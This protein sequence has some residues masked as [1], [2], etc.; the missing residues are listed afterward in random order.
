[1]KKL[2]ILFLT[3]SLKALAFHH[4][5]IVIAT[6]NNEASC[7]RNLISA[8]NQDYPHFRV[9]CINDA[10]TDSTRERI[11]K[12]VAEHEKGHLVH[13]INNETRQRALANYT[14]AIRNHTE[15]HEIIAIL[16]GDDALSHRQV[17]QTLEEYYSDPDVWLTYGQFRFMSTGQQGWCCPMPNSVINAHAFRRWPHGPSHLRTFY[18]WLFKRIALSDLMLNGVFFEMT[19]DLAM[20][21]P[22][23]EMANHHFAFVEQVLYDYNDMNPISDHEISKELQLF[24]DHYIRSLSPYDALSTA[25][26]WCQAF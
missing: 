14:N 17:L 3:L 8:L 25:P 4:Y 16:D 21:I 23:I 19:G 24:Y 2:F 20:M 18:S 12:I 11:E 15:D 7:E 10:S 1:M 9:I 6:Y 13:L 26:D 5:V 22:M